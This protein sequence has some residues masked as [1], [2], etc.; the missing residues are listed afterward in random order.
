MTTEV[1]FG[2]TCLVLVIGFIVVNEWAKH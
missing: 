1:E 2:V